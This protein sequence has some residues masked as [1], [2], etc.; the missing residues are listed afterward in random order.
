L[1]P[2]AGLRVYRRIV[3]PR[4]FQPGAYPGSSGIT[5]V[6]WPQNDYW[7]GAR[8]DPGYR[9]TEYEV[10]SRAKQL[11]GCDSGR[12]TLTGGFSHAGAW[13]LN[14]GVQNPLAFPCD[15]MWRAPN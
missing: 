15:A 6:N 11:N 13:Q 3:Y 1:G 12:R 7:L 10:T 5:L 8:V 14:A 2:R 9:P 4:N